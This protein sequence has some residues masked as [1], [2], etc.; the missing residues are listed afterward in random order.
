MST[1]VTV[2][3]LIP[4]LNEA[5]AIASVIRGVRHHVGMVLVIDDG[6]DD[7]T[8]E[9]AETAGAVCLRQ[10]QHQGKG[11]ALRAGL[12]H[13]ANLEFSHVLFIDG[14]GQHLPEDIPSLIR[15]ARETGADLVIGTRTFDR[16][17]MPAE[18]Y[19]SNRVGSRITSW[20][21]GCEIR[22]S[23]CGFRLARLAKL[24]SLRLQS[25]KYEIE[26]EILI[27]M[28]LA[29][30][31]LAHAPVSMVYQDGRGRSKMKPVRDTVHIC[32]WSLLFRYLR[33]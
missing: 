30:C 5:D 9:I 1:D 3:A 8:A 18:R 20:L 15:I 24:N 32:L 25:R 19:F 14:D 33:F 21:V 31:S 26:M 10:P 22:D 6:S 7:G 2:C 4:A 23:Q 17:R 12:A 28:R 29:G 11:T 13:I 16:E 27:K